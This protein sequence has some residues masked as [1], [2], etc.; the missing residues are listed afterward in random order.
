MKITVIVPLR[1]EVRN[2]EEC[3]HA[4]FA[5]QIP[6]HWHLHV[7]CI[8]GKSDDGTLLK[9][10]SLKEQY[11]TIEILTNEAQIT[12]TAFNIG[13]RNAIDSDYIQRV[14]ARQIISPN[15]IQQAVHKLQSDE[16]IWCVGGRMD[17]VYENETGKTIASVT[18]TSLGMG[19]GN[20]RVKQKSGFVDT[21]HTPMY[22][23][24]VFKKIGLFDESLIR[25]QDDDFNFRVAKAGGKIYLDVSIWTKY[26]VRGSYNQLWRQFFQYGYWKVYVNR[27]H[28]TFTTLR[29]IVPP[30]F[31]LYCCVAVFSWLFGGVFG[32]I[33][34]GAFL[35]YLLLVC[36]ISID[37][38]RKDSSLS[39][40]NL[41]KTFFILHFSYG[42][43]YLNGFFDFSIL[44]KKPADKHTQL[45]R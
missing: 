38:V 6:P 24:W 39:F 27:K 5:S 11:P 43:G 22:P 29:Q 25:N 28:K 8:D 7:L 44:R 23:T 32:T 37:L 45:S 21:V 19:L 15:Y 3:L 33:G 31:V 1:N 12:P 14:D 4:I 17:N 26:Y 34:S 30:F 35:F 36:L 20:S 42:L 10:Q 9:L 18:A 40:F 2:I 13:V 16:Q 41:A